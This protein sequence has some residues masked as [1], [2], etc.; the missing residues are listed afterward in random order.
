MTMG[1]MITLL[2]VFAIVGIAMGTV[3]VWTGH[4]K[5]GDIAIACILALAAWLLLT[6][7][8]LFATGDTKGGL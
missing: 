1:W 7:I 5:P 2:V 3:W 6:T 8:L 4:R